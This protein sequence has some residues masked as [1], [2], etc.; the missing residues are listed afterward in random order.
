M[1]EQVINPAGLLDPE[2]IVKP[3]KCRQIDDLIT[4][5]TCGWPKGNPCWSAADR[6]W[7]RTWTAFLE[8]RQVAAC[9]DGCG[10]NPQIS[11]L[12]LEDFDV[13]V[14]ILCVKDWISQRVFLVAI[15]DA[16][17]GGFPTLS[18]ADPD[19]QPRPAEAIIVRR[20]GHLRWNRRLLRPTA[21]GPFR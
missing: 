5:E 16:D 10:I 17:K 20:P 3:T 11:D 6:R 7:Q 18:L 2:I 8:G 21:A 19:H 9:T 12:R 14:G 15:L 13:L 1:V 4:S